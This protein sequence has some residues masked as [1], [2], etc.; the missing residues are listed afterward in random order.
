[1][2]VSISG[3]GNSLWWHRVDGFQSLINAHLTE[4]MADRATC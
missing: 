4:N 1:M 3:G 2:K